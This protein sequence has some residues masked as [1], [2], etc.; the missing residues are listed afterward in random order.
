L[1]GGA[2]CSLFDQFRKELAPMN[3][4]HLIA[5]LAEAA[6]AVGVTIASVVVFQFALLA[7]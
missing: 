5:R 3:E 6:L 1:A 7:G 2:I 4:S